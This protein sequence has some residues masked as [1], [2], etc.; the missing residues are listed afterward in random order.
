MAGAITGLHTFAADV[1][2]EPLS[3]LDTNYGL[4]LAGINNLNAFDNWYV[5]SGTADNL[6]VTILGQQSMTLAPGLRVTVQ[7]AATNTTTNPTL[8]VG[9][10]G[11]IVIRDAWGG[12]ILPAQLGAGTVRDFVYNGVTWIC[13]T[14]SNYNPAALLTLHSYKPA[15]TSRINAS[16]MA[17]DPDLTIAIPFSGMW[18]IQLV[19]QAA[20]NSSG[21]GGFQW[22]LNYSGSFVATSGSWVNPWVGTTNIPSQSSAITIQN[23]QTIS[24]STSVT[25]STAFTIPD[26]VT[27]SAQLLATST[28]TLGFSWGQR[29]NNSNAAVVFAGGSLTAS[30]LG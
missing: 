13:L 17:N 29:V 11:A 27:V 26:A 24:V 19:F 25:L 21:A 10:S 23:I 15:S 3:L 7:I 8:N 30:R 9:G 4:L 1:G 18:V 12:N 5:D 20:C 14:I 2:P 28:G 16:L 22:N 6:V